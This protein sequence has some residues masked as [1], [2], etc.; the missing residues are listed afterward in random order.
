MWGYE[1]MMIRYVQTKKNSNRDDI[2]QKG[3]L[4]NV[5][6]GPYFTISLS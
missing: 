2:M 1:W 3:E 6:M 5:Y 4:M